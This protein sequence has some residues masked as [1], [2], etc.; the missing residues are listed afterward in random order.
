MAVPVH[1]G[2]D[3]SGIDLPA[4]EATRS[5]V[6]GGAWRCVPRK[7]GRAAKPRG[8]AAQTSIV[9]SRPSTDSPPIR[10]STTSTT[11]LDRV[12]LEQAGSAHLDALG[13][14]PSEVAVAAGRWLRAGQTSAQFA[15]PVAGSSGTPSKGG[16]HP[17]TQVD[18]HRAEPGPSPPGPRALRLPSA[19]AG[20][21]RCRGARHPAPR[22]PPSRELRQVRPRSPQRVEVDDFHDR[23]R[24]AHRNHHRGVRAGERRRTRAGRAQLRRDRPGRSVPAGE[25]FRA[26]ELAPEPRIT[27]PLGTWFRVPHTVPLTASRAARLDPDRHDASGLLEGHRP[28]GRD[29]AE[30]PGG[31]QRERRAHVRVPGEGHLPAG[32]KMRTRRS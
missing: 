16:E 12:G 8:A 15:L 30:S 29:L 21:P 2:G 26:D 23:E 7:P 32:V 17:R 22:S 20:R 9:P 24:Q 14:P 27:A 10:T 31:G 4:T 5:Q 6:S 28:R 19:G 13:D 18:G 25:R 3:Q 11:T 1:S